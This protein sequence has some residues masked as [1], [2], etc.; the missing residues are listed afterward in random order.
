MPA[1]KL[2]LIIS[3]GW[4]TVLWSSVSTTGRMRRNGSL[5]LQLPSSRVDGKHYLGTVSIMALE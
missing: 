2:S 4:F 1:K 3:S 5:L